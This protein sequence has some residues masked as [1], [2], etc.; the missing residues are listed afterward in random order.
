MSS[1]VTPP[2]MILGKTPQPVPQIPIRIRV[3]RGVPLRGPVLTDNHTRPSLRQ[4]KPFLKHHY[5]S[6]SPRR[7]HQFP[8]EISLK[9]SIS[10]SL[11]ATIGFSRAF[12]LELT[13]FG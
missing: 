11:S 1:A 10:S 9:A 8:L 5:G 6:A 2:R 4:T 13:R 7:A 12:S 3:G